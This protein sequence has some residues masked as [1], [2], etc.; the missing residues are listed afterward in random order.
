MISFLK[1]IT[2]SKSISD[3]LICRFFNENIFDKKMDKY[4]I[5]SNLASEQAVEQMI[6]NICHSDAPELNDL[7]QEIYLALLEYRDDRIIELYEAGQ[8][9]YFIVRIISNQYF[10][11]TSPFYMRYRRFL[12]NSDNINDYT[13]Y[14][15]DFKDLRQHAPTT[16][17][18]K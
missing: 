13:N 18:P 15:E 2:I 8:L 7:A 17:S 1:L 11:I 5:I 4:E 16:H 9:R 10:S 3:D 6:H 12:R 14:G